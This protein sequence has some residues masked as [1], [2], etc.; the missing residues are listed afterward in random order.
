MFRLAVSIAFLFVAMLLP[1]SAETRVALVIGN[2][3][4]KHLRALKNPPNDARDF[5]D[6]LKKLGFEVDLGIDL[7]LADMHNKVGAFARRAQTADV[8]LAFFAGHGVQAP[9]PMSAANVVNYLLPTDIDDIKTAADLSGGFLVTARDIVGRMQV[10]TSVRILILDAC[11]DNAIPQ[12]LADNTRSAVIHRGLGPEPKTSGTLIAYST[13]PDTTAADGEGRN[14]EFMKALL[15]HIAD[16]GLDIRLLFADVRKDV[17]RTSR[18]AQTPE[19]SDSLDGRF[20][21][22]AAVAAPPPLPAGPAADDVTWRY[23]R[24]TRDPDLL[25]RFIAEFPASLQRREAEERIRALE[26]TNAATAPNASTPG[27][28]EGPSGGKTV[29]REAQ[30]VVLYEEDPAD[31]SGTRFSGGVTW[32]TELTAPVPGQKP[33]LVIHGDIEIPDKK[34]R[35][36]LT[37][38]HNQDKQLPASHVFDI[39]F[40]L[41]P[42]FAHGG[43]ANVPGILAKEGEDS[44]GAPLNGLAVKVTD[45]YFLVG[46]SVAEAEMQRNVQL[47]K[48][49]VWFDIPIVYTDGKRAIIAVEKGLPGERIFSEALAAWEEPPPPALLGAACRVVG[50]CR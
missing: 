28:G 13:Q 42:G 9:D 47:L 10:A 20:A 18:G 46:L 41:P 17:I 1:A 37:L 3:A 21:F 33:E 29:E 36:R 4:Y 34:V 31:P 40:T 26:Q 5:A 27:Q 50:I 25:R 22:K 2:G 12:R 44:R 39:K 15:A 11:R 35:A 16:P 7:T 24:D 19:T 38:T 23:L 45:G 6:A 49:R 8:A 43:I 48:E 14:S 30:K 32:S